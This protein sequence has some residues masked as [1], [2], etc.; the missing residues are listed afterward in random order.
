MDIRHLTFEQYRYF[1][2]VG[3]GRQ[4]PTAQVDPTFRG[5]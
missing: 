2:D 3:L 1:R 5:W 4:L